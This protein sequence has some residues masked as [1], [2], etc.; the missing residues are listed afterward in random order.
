MAGPTARADRPGAL[1]RQSL[2]RQA[3]FAIAA[4][5]QAAGAAVTLIAGPVELRDPPASG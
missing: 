4:A 5:A 3:G 1:H 2:Q